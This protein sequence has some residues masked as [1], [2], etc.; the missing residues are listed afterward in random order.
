MNMNTNTRKK[1]P[2][3]YSSKNLTEHAVPM[4]VCQEPVFYLKFLVKKRHNSKYIAFRV[5]PLAL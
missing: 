5:M 1:T 3:M 4:L 2:I